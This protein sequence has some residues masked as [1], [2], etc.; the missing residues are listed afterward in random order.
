MASAKK[1]GSRSRKAKEKPEHGGEEKD[2]H[3]HQLLT[4]TVGTPTWVTKGGKKK[5]KGA[6]KEVKAFLQW[7]VKQ[8]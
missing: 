4:I 3:S 8:M 1:T 6:P 7:L 5:K 2:H